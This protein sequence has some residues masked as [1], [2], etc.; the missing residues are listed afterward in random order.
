MDFCAPTIL[1]LVF[2][3]ISIIFQISQGSTFTS[4]IVNVFFIGLWA[5][6]LNYLCSINWAPVAWALVFLPFVIVFLIIVLLLETYTTNWNFYN[7]TPTPTPFYNVT[8]TSIK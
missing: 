7:L 1:Y 4:V 5:L 6:L 2:S 3:A 8:P